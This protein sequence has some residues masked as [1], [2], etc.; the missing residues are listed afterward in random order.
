MGGVRRIQ[1]VDCGKERPLAD[2]IGIERKQADC[3]HMC[4]CLSGYAIKFNDTYNRT[5]YFSWMG[6]FSAGTTG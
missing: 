3:M 2:S 1:A 5:G 4:T 6:A